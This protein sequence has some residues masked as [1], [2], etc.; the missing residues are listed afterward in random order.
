MEDHE[1]KI[2]NGNIDINFT[3]NTESGKLSV[4]TD[5]RASGLMIEKAIEVLALELS[6]VS[7]FTVEAVIARLISSVVLN[8]DDK[9]E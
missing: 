6:K 5:V 4:A 8:K 2:I 9:D 1:N 3:F 7:G